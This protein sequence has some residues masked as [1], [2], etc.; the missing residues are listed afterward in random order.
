MLKTLV[1]SDYKTLFRVF[2]NFFNS[3][4][5]INPSSSIQF[6]SIRVFFNFLFKLIFRICFGKVGSNTRQSFLSQKDLFLLILLTLFVFLLV[7]R[8]GCSQ[9]HLL[10]RVRRTWRS[11]WEVLRQRLLPGPSCPFSSRPCPRCQ[12]LWVLW[13]ADVEALKITCRNVKMLFIPNLL[14][15]CVV[16]Y[17][18][19]KCI[20]FLKCHLF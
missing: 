18:G 14:H 20:K 12:G 6:M 15:W 4:L 7:T 17:K 3:N 16:F 9:P 10:R 13:E 2:L 1:L 11:D 8:R 19:I 5:P